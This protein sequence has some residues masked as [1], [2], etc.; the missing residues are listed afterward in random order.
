M[1]AIFNYIQRAKYMRYLCHI[2]FAEAFDEPKG[3]IREKSYH[4]FSGTLMKG[5]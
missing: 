1:K 5:L 3:K 2:P 4:V